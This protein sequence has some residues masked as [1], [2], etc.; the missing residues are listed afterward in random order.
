M[1]RARVRYIEEETIS[2]TCNLFEKTAKPAPFDVLNHLDGGDEVKLSLEWGCLKIA[3]NDMVY[4]RGRFS[5]L[6]GLHMH[7]CD[8]VL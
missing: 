4:D 1:Q 3:V 2:H 5:P 8:I 7:L 6:D